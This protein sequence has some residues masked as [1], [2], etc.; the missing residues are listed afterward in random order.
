MKRT[1]YKRFTSFLLGLCMLAALLPANILPV[2]AADGSVSATI[3]IDNGDGM[4]EDSEKV[5]T[6]AHD[7]QGL[8]LDLRNFSPVVGS[9]WEVESLAFYPT[10][11][12]SE[13]GTVFWYNGEGEYF[14][15]NGTPHDKLTNGVFQLEN[16]TPNGNMPLEPGEYRILVYVGNGKS[17]SE[18]EEIQYYSNEVFTIGD[19]GTPPSYGGEQSGN[20][21]ISTT[22]LPDATYKQEY[23]YVMSAIPGTAGNTLT[24]STDGLPAGLAIDASTG[25]ITGAPTEDGSFSVSFSVTET[26]TGKSVTKTL[27][28]NVIREQSSIQWETA[29]VSLSNY[30]KNKTSDYTFKLTPTE[31]FTPEAETELNITGFDTDFTDSTFSGLPA[32]ITATGKDGSLTLTF[33]GSATVPAEGLE[34][35]ATDAM[36]G[37]LNCAPCIEILEYENAEIGWTYFL[38]IF[39]V[40]SAQYKLTILNYADSPMKD[41]NLRAEIYDSSDK[42]VSNYLVS[43]DGTVVFAIDEDMHNKEYKIKLT[44]YDYVFAESA[45]FTA[46]AYAAQEGSLTLDIDDYSIMTIEPNVEAKNIIFEYNTSTDGSGHTKFYPRITNKNEYLESVHTN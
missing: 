23:T 41:V 32:G 2:F 15:D 19:T 26:E 3:Y 9:G 29:E 38:T 43:K 14:C 37:E 44:Y 33:D 6:F 17:G 5:D 46:D 31:A 35:T 25:I 45:P 30:I 24:W 16:F 1:F 10:D 22:S 28:L 21:Y 4:Y 11:G 7:Q 36:N 39:F 8:I 18:Y 40:D 12:S 27:T 20:P 42:L 13:W 34:F